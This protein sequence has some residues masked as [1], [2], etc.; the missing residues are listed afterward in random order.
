MHC[1]PWQAHRVA[2]VAPLNEDE[3][4]LMMKLLQRY[5]DSEMDQWAKWRLPTGFGQVFIEIR[6]T[7]T[8]GYEVE[9]Y[10]DMTKSIN[11][12]N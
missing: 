5:S 2:D 3:F 1:P 7:P 12:A 4:A 9:S 10:H 8:P 11:D 6:M